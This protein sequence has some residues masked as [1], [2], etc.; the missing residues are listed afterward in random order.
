MEDREIAR[1]E[2]IKA[3]IKKEIEKIKKSA[4]EERE[5]LGI[6][7]NNE[8]ISS[9]KKFWNFVW[10]DNSVWSWLTALILAFI[11]VKFIFFPLLSLATGT[12]LPLVVVE[13]SSMHHSSNYIE[14]LLLTFGGFSD[15]WNQYSDWY[16]DNNITK[17]EFSNFPLRTGFD[18]G[19]I[20]FVIGDSSPEIGDVIIFEANQAYP[21]I[22]RV[23]NI[24]EINNQIIYSTK[25]DNN[26]EPGRAQLPI[27]TSIK[28]SQIIGKAVLRIPLLGWVKLVF[29]EIIN[30]FRNI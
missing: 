20:M 12:A 13:S 18:K 9:L 16:E 21:I 19:D 28:E 26:N 14:N 1:S 2:D 4:Q 5:L 17:E 6:G 15:W 3:E 25:G 29:V 30:A 27:E 23:V 10:K 22:H 11:I 8:V 7:K 24:Q